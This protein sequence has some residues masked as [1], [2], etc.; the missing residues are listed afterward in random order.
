MVFLNI[1]FRNAILCSVSVTLSGDILLA[2]SFSCR[3]TLHGRKNLTFFKLRGKG[4][5]SSDI[6]HQFLAR[7]TGG[8]TEM[9]YEKYHRFP[10]KSPEIMGSFMSIKKG[11]RP[12]CGSC[13]NMN[14]AFY[15]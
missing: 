4:S 12:V 6:C 9:Y 11:G 15:Y 14:P 8:Q 10:H 5:S 1:Y 7:Q 13:S 3:K 2:I